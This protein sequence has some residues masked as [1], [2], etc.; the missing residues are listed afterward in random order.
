MHEKAAL[1]VYVERAAFSWLVTIPGLRM[2]LH[3]PGIVLV[4][5]FGG[6]G[7]FSFIVDCLNQF[8][9]GIMFFKR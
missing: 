7:F 4:L 9:V 2:M 5:V 6:F 8:A 1:S 3:K